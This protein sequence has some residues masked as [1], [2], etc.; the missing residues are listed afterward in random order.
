MSLGFAPAVM[1]FKAIP[2]EM[3]RAAILKV[4]GRD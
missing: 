1:I 4:L 3:L 2:A